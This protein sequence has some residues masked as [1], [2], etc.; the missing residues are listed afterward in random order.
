MD[1]SHN[2]F[3]PKKA[4]GQRFNT[5]KPAKV[6]TKKNSDGSETILASKKSQPTAKRGLI[7]EKKVSF[8]Q[9]RQPIVKTTISPSG[10]E[11]IKQVTPQTNQ[12][13]KV[14]VKK[15]VP[16]GSTKKRVPL[17]Q[18]IK[19]GIFKAIPK[20]KSKGSSKRLLSKQVGSKQVGSKQ[21]INKKM[22]Q[23]SNVKKL[24][25]KQPIMKTLATSKNAKI[26]NPLARKRKELNK[27]SVAAEALKFTNPLTKAMK[28]GLQSKGFNTKEMSQAAIIEKFYNEFVSNKNDKKSHLEPLEEG[29]LQNHYLYN[30]DFDSFDSDN[31]GGLADIQAVVGIGKNV[32]GKLKDFRAK[33][34][35]ARAAKKAGTNVAIPEVENK[36]GAETDK[37]LKDLE[38]Q[39]KG[40]E[41]ITKD[42][43]KKSIVKYI[44]FGVA[45]LVVLG[46]IIF[47]ARRKK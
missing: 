19:K 41:P 16:V 10:K 44:I 8:Q 45:G 7:T 42:E 29:F 40:G 24:I 2:D 28:I 17:G 30:A 20:S 14:L 35:A 26:I 15:R 22:V 4:T 33:R 1:N 6:M 47:L 32:V 27:K 46:L 34:K 11:T 25:P 43:S 39:Q 36:L 38:A 37:V 9:A 12:V 3:T 13:K 23:S 5:S 21:L 31:I 18:K